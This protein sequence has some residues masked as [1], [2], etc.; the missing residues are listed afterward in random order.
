MSKIYRLR[1]TVAR[2]H[3][4]SIER[5]LFDKTKFPH[6]NG[7]LFGRL[8]PD[9]QQDIYDLLQRL[10]RTL[11]GYLTLIKPYNLDITIETSPVNLQLNEQ[12]ELVKSELG[13]KP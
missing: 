12:A 3:T 7:S 4:T 2:R 9:L 1:L 11:H 6:L 8:L 13:L 10:K 5:L